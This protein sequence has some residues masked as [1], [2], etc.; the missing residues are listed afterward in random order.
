MGCGTSAPNRSARAASSLEVLQQNSMKARTQIDEVSSSLE[1]L[2]NAPPE[3]LREA[4]DRY[5]RNVRN[6]NDYAEA[7]RE[8]DSD[9]RKNGNAYLGQWQKDASTISDPELRAI[10]EQRQS[11]MK[12]KMDSMR[13][14]VTAAAQSFEAFLRDI[15][16][17]RKVIGNDL[18]STG[19]AGVRNTALAQSVRDEGARVKMAIQEAEAAIANLRAQITPT[20]D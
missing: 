6:M 4:Y 7:I 16:D 20:S 17:I 5:D 11:E 1:V 3:K 14:T 15:N 13:A 2:L 9:L 12:Q 19:Q 18:T 10:A 8:N